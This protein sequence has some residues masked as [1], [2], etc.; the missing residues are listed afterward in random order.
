MATMI[1]PPSGW[2][3]GFPKL[4]P[5]SRKKDV[6]IWLVEQGYP[7]EEINRLGK[8]FFCGYYEV[9]EKAVTKA[10]QLVEDFYDVIDDISFENSDYR[11]RMSK[12]LAIMCCREVLGDMGTDRGY[13]FWKEV[14]R[15][16]NLLKEI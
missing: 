6:K 10:K 16:I 12:K 13:A 8:Q 14:E 3:Y 9:D 5:E 11:F 4:L 1:D 2:K 15:E 7:Q